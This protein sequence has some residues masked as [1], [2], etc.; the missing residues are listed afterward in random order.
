M[1]DRSRTPLRIERSKRPTLQFTGQPIPELC[2]AE[3]Q[4]PIVAV[5]AVMVEHEKRLK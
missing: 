4:W 3:Q 1:W 5:D 2:L